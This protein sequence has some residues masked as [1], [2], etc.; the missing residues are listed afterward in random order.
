MSGVHEKNSSFLSWYLLSWRFPWLDYT[1]AIEVSYFK[2]WGWTHLYM[3]K[4]AHRIFLA[5]INFFPW[6]NEW[7]VKQA[8]YEILQQIA[9]LDIWPKVYLLNENNELHQDFTIVEYIAGETMDRCSDEDIIALARCLKKLH[10]LPIEYD[11]TEELPYVCE[12]YDEFAWWEDKY[13]E[14]YDLPGLPWVYELY[15]A[16]KGELWERFHALSIFDTCENVCLCHADLKSE[17]IIKT[18]SWVML[19]D[20]ECGW[21]DIPETDIWRL[22]SWCQFTRNQEE[23]FLSTYFTSQPAEETLKRIYAVKMVLD[24]FRILEDYCIHKRKPYSA[25]AMI[26]DLL[27]YR[28]RFYAFQ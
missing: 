24:F 11:E 3:I 19:I 15:N 2:S 7:K 5:R 17:N 18:S 12:I 8:E 6:K 4:N 23:L 9:L 1:S 22:F 25:E 20:R 10:A 28:E 27:A 14:Q 13:I 26:A 21:I 16:L